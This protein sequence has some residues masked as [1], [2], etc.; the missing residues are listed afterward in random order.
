MGGLIKMEERNGNVSFDP[1]FV[2]GIVGRCKLNILQDVKDFFDELEG[3]ETIYVKTT[4]GKKLY[5]MESDD[6]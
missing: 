6:E 1:I 5:I 3:F 4:K 2:I